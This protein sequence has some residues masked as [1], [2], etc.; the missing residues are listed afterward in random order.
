M[1]VPDIIDWVEEG[2]F[3]LTTAFSIRDRLDELEELITQLNNRGLAG[4]GIKTKDSLM[5]FQGLV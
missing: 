5:K 3:L 4:I 2:E 1:E